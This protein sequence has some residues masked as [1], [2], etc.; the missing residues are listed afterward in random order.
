MPLLIN[1]EELATNQRLCRTDLFRRGSSE[2]HG[3]IHISIGMIQNEKY[4]KQLFRFSK[5][6]L[7]Y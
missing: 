4:I 3:D 6:I 7:I 2:D 5:I 1:K